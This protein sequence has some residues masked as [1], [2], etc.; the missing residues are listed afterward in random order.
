MYALRS[1]FVSRGTAMAKILVGFLLG[2]LACAGALWALGFWPFER[3]ATEEGHSAAIATPAPTPPA[4]PRSAPALPAPAPG[5]ALPPASPPA[6][7]APEP[8]PADALRAAMREALAGKDAN[9]LEIARALATRLLLLAGK[10]DAEAHAVLGDAEFDH[11]IPDIVAFRGH[12]FVRAVEEANA[13]RWFPPSE[14]DAFLDAVRA[15]ARLDA[16]AKRLE[17]DRA[18]RCFDGVRAEVAGDPIFGGYVWETMDASPFVLFWTDGTRMDPDTLARLPAAERAKRVEEASI[19]RPSWRRA[20]AE[21]GKVFPQVYAEILRRYGKALDLRDLM[22]EWGGRPDYPASKRSFR[23]GFPIPVFVFADEEAFR[24][25]YEHVLRCRVP[26]G[27]WGGLDDWSGTLVL[28]DGP[29]GDREEP[30]AEHLSLVASAVFHA[31]TRQRNEWADPR[32]PLTFFDEG[33]A[34]QT[35]SATMNKDRTLAFTGVARPRL[36]ELARFEAYVRKE[37]NKGIQVFPLKDFLDFEGY[38]TVSQWALEH[39]GPMGGAGFSLFRIQAW[40]FV[41]FLNEFQGGKYRASWEQL[42]ADMVNVPRDAT[43]YAFASFRTRFR[44]VDDAKWKALEEEF[45][46]FYRTLPTMDLAALGPTPPS[47][48]DWP[49][50]TDPGR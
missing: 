32:W 3:E 8:S 34:R 29:S 24:D 44:L 12:D 35:S 46:A 10:D 4:P 50:Y 25:H 23:D 7:P 22:D 9:A 45:A 17:T 11:P 1:A 26:S 15:G 47:L 41:Y 39:W 48:D 49:G 40:A 6:A 38:G 14:H 16:H 18:Y 37:F 13:K 33:F 19:K 27:R 20:L 30:L 2:V 42:V 5:A 36:R 21:K 43:G 31:F 28:H